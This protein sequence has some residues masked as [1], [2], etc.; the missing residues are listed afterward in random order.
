M[1]CG[2]S[3]SVSLLKYTATPSEEILDAGSPLAQPDSDSTSIVKQ[4]TGVTDVAFNDPTSPAALSGQLD[5]GSVVHV[6]T[7]TATDLVPA[8]RLRAADK[9][10]HV[11]GVTPLTHSGDTKLAREEPD[12]VVVSESLPIA[13]AVRTEQESGA[14]KVDAASCTVAIELARPRQ[15]LEPI[16][17]IAKRSPAAVPH[18]H[19]S[20]LAEKVRPPVAPHVWLCTRESARSKR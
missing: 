19:S 8:P 5:A 10:S 6:A 18:T 7:E 9:A 2:A 15:E 12:T 13:G 14:R 20:E 17:P 11:R 16:P 3:K 4:A 1:G